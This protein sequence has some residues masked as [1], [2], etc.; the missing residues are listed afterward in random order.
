MCRKKQ[1]M[2]NRAK[3][4]H[5][6]KYWEDDKSFKCDVA[7]TIHKARWEYLNGIL[8]LGL[9]E[10][11]SRLFW[12]YIRSEKQDNVGKTALSHKGKLVTND[13]Q[14]AEILI[15]QVCFY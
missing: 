12:R 8:Q 4:H 9:E 14:K 6:K 5:Q 10:G 13:I 1:R 11:N 15:D 3:N 2:F 7:C